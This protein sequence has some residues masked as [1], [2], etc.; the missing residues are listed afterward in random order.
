MSIKKFRVPP[1]PKDGAH[2]QRSRTFMVTNRIFPDRASTF[3][4]TAAICALAGIV[5]ASYAQPR[6]LRNV[7]E[8]F[9]LRAKQEARAGEK[10]SIP[11]AVYSELSESADKSTTCNE[12]HRRALA[13]YRI[14][15]AP[16]GAQAFA[17]LGRGFCYCKEEGNCR[18]WILIYRGQKYE[19]ILELEEAETFGFI[20]SKAQMP[21]LIVWTRLAPTELGATVYRFYRWK[22][23]DAG[24]WVERYEY[25]DPHCDS[26]EPYIHPIP[27]IESRLR[28][29]QLKSLRAKPP[30][31]FCPFRGG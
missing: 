10:V 12:T 16:K 17:V 21:L 1:I 6:F 7:V 15:P 4:A 11:D 20:S 26:D 30:F 29:P 8:E 13:M 23:E 27:Q 5:P 2:C 24:A 19:K 14:V 28:C 31:S 18:F 22:Y 3:L 25:A 9:A